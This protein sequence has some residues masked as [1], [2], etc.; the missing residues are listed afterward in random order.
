MLICKLILFLLYVDD[1]MI[2]S[3]AEAVVN[4]KV[5]LFS[6]LFK[7]TDKTPYG[8]IKGYFGCKVEQNK[9]RIC[10]TQPVKFNG[11]LKNLELTML[12]RNDRIH[13]PNQVVS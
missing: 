10:L 3:G 12:R 6:K 1:C 11:L 5:I 7:V 13:Q 9:H 4:N 8:I 2:L